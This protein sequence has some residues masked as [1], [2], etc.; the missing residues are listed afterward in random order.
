MAAVRPSVPALQWKLRLLAGGR[1]REDI[2][3]G[4]QEGAVLVYSV[5]A[6]DLISLTELMRL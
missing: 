2:H 4:G 5:C 6:G 3:T 1:R